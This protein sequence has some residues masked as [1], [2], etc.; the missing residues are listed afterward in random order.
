MKDVKPFLHQETGSLYISLVV[1]YS[2]GASYCKFMLIVHQ[3]RTKCTYFVNMCAIQLPI[4]KHLYLN[5]FCLFSCPKLMINS[6]YL[7]WELLGICAELGLIWFPQRLG[8]RRA[9][10]LSKTVSPVLHSELTSAVT[11]SKGGYTNTHTHTSGFDLTTRDSY[12][13]ILVA[14]FTNHILA[15]N[16]FYESFRMNRS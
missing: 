2:T 5:H 12:F 9:S 15:K 8:G 13:T 7:R 4:L 11:P 3:P 16:I 6:R 14:V 1:F 10:N